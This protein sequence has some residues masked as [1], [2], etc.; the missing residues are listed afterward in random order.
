MVSYFHVKGSTDSL[1]SARKSLYDY[2]SRMPDRYRYAICEPVYIDRN[3]VTVAGYV[4]I[5][6]GKMIWDSGKKRYRLNKNGKI[7]AYS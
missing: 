4:T 2:V 1:I 7:T 5:I 6:N 3:P